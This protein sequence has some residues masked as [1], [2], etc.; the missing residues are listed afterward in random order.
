MFI[1]P[2]NL[3]TIAFVMILNN[4]LQRLI[5]RNWVMLSGFITFG[6]DTTRASFVP[7]GSFPVSKNRRTNLITEAPT[8]FQHL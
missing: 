3:P 7:S 1:I 5:G 6:I 2:F 8:V 4:T